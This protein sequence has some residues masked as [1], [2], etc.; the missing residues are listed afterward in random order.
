MLQPST[1][2]LSDVQKSSSCAKFKWPTLPYLIDGDRI[3]EGGGGFP[4]F[5]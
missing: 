1:I 5:S 3:G 2:S 4:R